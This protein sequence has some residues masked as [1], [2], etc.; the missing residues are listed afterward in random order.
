MA[1]TRKV[2]PWRGVNVNSD[3][4]SEMITDGLA[5]TMPRLPR[6]RAR[7]LERRLKYFPLAPEIAKASHQK[8]MEGIRNLTALLPGNVKREVRRILQRE[9]H[10]SRRGFS[11]GSGVRRVKYL[12]ILTIRGVYFYTL[13][14]GDFRATRKML[15]KK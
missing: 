1:E 15:I 11:I 4:K 9:R 2:N 6:R 3:P 8:N 14:A 13:T 7:W 10:P 5:E 12:S